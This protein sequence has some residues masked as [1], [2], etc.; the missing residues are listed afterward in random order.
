MIVFVASG[1]CVSGTHLS[2]NNMSGVGEFP[3]VADMLVYMGMGQDM[4]TI[5]ILGVSCKKTK[6]D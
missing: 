2:H 1:L 5:L 3:L 6:P 4:A